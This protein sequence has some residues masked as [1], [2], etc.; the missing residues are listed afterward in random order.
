MYGEEIVIG[1]V[2]ILY[3]TI[4]L[5]YHSRG[6]GGTEDVQRKTPPQPCRTHIGEEKGIIPM[7]AGRKKR[8]GGLRSRSEKGGKKPLLP[9]LPDRTVLAHIV[10]KLP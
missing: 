6:Y 7:A 10:P 3:L 5:Q 2:S 8:D 4:S 9:G 1:L